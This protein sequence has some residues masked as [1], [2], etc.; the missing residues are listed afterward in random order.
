[1]LLSYEIV[2]AIRQRMRLGVNVSNLHVHSVSNGSLRTSRG[3]DAW[4]FTLELL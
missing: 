1:M 3:R 4:R 2:A